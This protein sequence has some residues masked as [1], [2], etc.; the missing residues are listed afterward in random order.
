MQE[1]KSY[2]DSLPLQARERYEKKLKLVGLQECP[3][4]LA[5]A[6]WEDDVTKWPGVEF[7]DIVMYLI[8]TP[9]EYTREKLKAYKS[10]D[11]YNYFTS[12][13][14]G[15]C[16]INKEFS[17]LKNIVKP[18]Q[19]L[20]NPLHCPWVAVKRKDGSICTSHCTCMAG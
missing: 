5:D 8:G 12:G 14:V 6:A 2:R 10:L 15:T 18:S 19:H 11:A 16:E 7:P 20:S 3:Y 17:V 1:K 4:A 9:G 13:W